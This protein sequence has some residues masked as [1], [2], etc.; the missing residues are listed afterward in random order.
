MKPFATFLYF[1]KNGE[2]K[3]PIMAV[4]IHITIVVKTLLKGDA[5]KPYIH[6]GIIV[7]ETQ[8]NL[9]G[10]VILYSVPHLSQF[11]VL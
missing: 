1:T 3:E 7:K 5:N 9:E 8:I 2:N 4:A 6:I 10:D 11:I